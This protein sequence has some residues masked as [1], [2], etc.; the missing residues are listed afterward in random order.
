MS[1]THDQ[2]DSIEDDSPDPSPALRARA[3]SGLERFLTGWGTAA[4]ER[5][6]RAPGTAG[7]SQ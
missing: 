7:G 6:G 2:Q 5:H 4:D 3:E 1:H